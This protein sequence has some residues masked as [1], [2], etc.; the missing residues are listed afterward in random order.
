MTDIISLL[1]FLKVPGINI[2]GLPT[3]LTVKKS[4]PDFIEL[5]AKNKK[6]KF[7]AIQS[8]LNKIML[9]RTVKSVNL[10]LPGI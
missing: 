6:E 8:I 9:R 4:H 7:Q 10:N 5:D 1:E 2:W 3:P